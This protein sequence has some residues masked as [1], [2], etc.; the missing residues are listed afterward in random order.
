MVY[1]EQVETNEVQDPLSVP[2]RLLLYFI[3]I[4]DKGQDQY[5]CQ[6]A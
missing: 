5:S 1:I 2:Y 6:A 4:L 3:I